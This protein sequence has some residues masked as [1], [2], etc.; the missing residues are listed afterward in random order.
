MGA[1]WVLRGCCVSAARVLRDTVCVLRE[2]CV[3]AACVGEDKELGV[4][5]SEVKC[6][7]SC[8]RDIHKTETAAQG[9]R[10]TSP[11][12]ALCS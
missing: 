5:E 12:D 11:G 10:E 2:C 9:G 4:S 8:E 1:A 3:S 6:V 7:G